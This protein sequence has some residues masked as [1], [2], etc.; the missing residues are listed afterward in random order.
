MCIIHDFFLVTQV[1]EWGAD[2][3]IVGSAI[4]KILG[5]AASP[6]EGLAKLK[7]FTEDVKNS[8]S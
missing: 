6:E 1:V 3:V 4:V 2:G 7:K 5:E 8:I